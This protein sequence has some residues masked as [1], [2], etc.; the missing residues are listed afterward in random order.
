ME[1]TRE[2]LTA[3]L[4]AAIQELPADKLVAALDFIGFLNSKYGQTLPT[5]GSADAI[6]HVLEHVGPLQFER[7]ELDMLLA[8]IEDMRTH[9]R[10]SCGE[11]FT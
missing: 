7:G 10:D 1:Q 5:R 8:D 9:D 4:V 11:L 6:V 3:H 2:Q